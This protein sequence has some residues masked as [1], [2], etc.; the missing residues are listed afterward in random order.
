MSVIILENMEFH[1]YHGCLE[2]EK[3]LGNT[4]LVTLHIHL[5]TAVADITDN[6]NDTINYQLIYNEVK[7]QMEVPSLLI[8]NV[9]ERILQAL[10]LKF[11]QISGLKIKLSKLNPPLGAKVHAVSIEKEFIK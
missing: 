6:L 10:I 5:D 1:S 7:S 9:S 8:E 3:I 11:D 4:F 2:H